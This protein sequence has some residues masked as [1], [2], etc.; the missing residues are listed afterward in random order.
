MKLSTTISNCVLLLLLVILVVPRSQAATL[1]QLQ[2]RQLNDSNAT[3]LNIDSTNTTEMWIHD[4]Q[5]GS[6]AG[7]DM[8]TVQ[9][10]QELE[11]EF[12]IFKLFLEHAEQ[13]WQ[14]RQKEKTRQAKRAEPQ[15]PPPPPAS[16]MLWP[17]INTPTLPSLANFFNFSFVSSNNQDVNNDEDDDDDG[18][19]IEEAFD[20]DEIS[21]ELQFLLSNTTGPSELRTMW[22]DAQPGNRT[23]RVANTGMNVA[24]Y[25]NQMLQ[26]ITNRLT[27]LGF[28]TTGVSMECREKTI[29]DTSQF[30]ASRMPAFAFQLG[31]DK[32]FQLPVTTFGN[33]EYINAWVVG[34]TMRN[35][36][37]C[38]DLYSCDE[39]DLLGLAGAE[40]EVVAAA[41]AADDDDDDSVTTTAAS[42]TSI[43]STST[44]IAAQAI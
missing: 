14:A 11:R 17:I 39:D 34:L 32:L 13:Q 16:G 4:P 23:L 8:E 43:T 28:H 19:E 33:S 7:S 3:K 1:F 36:N 40:P 26:M 15:P 31:R 2:G 29:C 5:T 38:D 21:S 27:N 6:G 42:D 41:A 18:D 22:I 30:V 37:F 24:G 9:L 35:E 25:I 44:T 10:E 20:E 12:N